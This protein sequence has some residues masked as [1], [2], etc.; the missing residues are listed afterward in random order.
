MKKFLL[1]HHK[2]YLGVRAVIAI[3]A[4]IM[5]WV[6]AWHLATSGRLLLSTG[7]DG[8]SSLQYGIEFLIGVVL[9]CVVNSLHSNAGLEAPPLSAKY[10]KGFMLFTRWLVAIP[11]TGKLDD[12]VE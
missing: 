1:R 4:S 11:G 3:Y 2:G 6:G 5:F 7:N 8:D 10:R 12:W 9:C